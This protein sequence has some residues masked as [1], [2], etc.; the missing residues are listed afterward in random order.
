[1]IELLEGK[2]IEASP[3]KAVF[4]CGGVGYAPHITMSLYD[5]LKVGE[6]KTVHTRAIYRENE[7]LLFGF[8]SLAERDT[9]DRLLK[10]SG[11]GPKTALG[12]ISGTTPEDLARRINDADIAALSKL[13][14]IGK[15]T[16]E[17]MALELAGKLKIDSTIGDTESSGSSVSQIETEAT[18]ALVSLGFPKAGAEK[19]VSRALKS[20]DSPSVEELIKTAL[21]NSMG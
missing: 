8:S 4:L 21:K 6:L 7:Q 20:L 5:S 15:K 1:M 10:V 14:G 11:I 3:V 13:P 12:I 17:R 18:A 19:S 16:A 2:V 9:F